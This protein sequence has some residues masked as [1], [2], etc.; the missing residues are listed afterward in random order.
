MVGKRAAQPR[1]SVWLTP[2]AGR[3]SGGLDREK[4]V[5]A[6]VRLL[7]EVGDT[8]F[9]MRLLATELNV[10]PMSVYWYVANKDDLLE[11]ALDAVA[12]GI[13]L[14]GA[15]IGRDWREDLRALAGAWRRTMVAHPWAIRCYGEYLNIGPQSLR[16]SQYAQTV[17]ARSPLSEPDQAAALSAVFQY[18]YGF[19]STESRWL[20]YGR[21]T[22]RTVDEFVEEVADSVAVAL[23]GQLGRGTL[24]RHSAHTMAELRDRDF[25]RALTWL[26][27]GMTA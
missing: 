16:F 27:T 10:T 24:Q 12:G 21:K 5:A 4:I 1:E 6:A 20:E 3:K 7:D 13:E 26:L 17:V 25:D 18:V 23:A 8:G 2:Q 22:G 9:S 11:L 15:D 19:A 14:P